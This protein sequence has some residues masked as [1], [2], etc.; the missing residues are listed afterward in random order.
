MGG[1]AI[2]KVPVIRLEK[3]R[4][5]D[6]KNKI[7]EIFSPR[8]QID[9]LI[10]VPGKIDFGDLDVLYLSESSQDIKNFIIEKIN[11]IE[12]VSNGD[13]LSIGYK[14]ESDEYFQ[15]DFIKCKNINTSKF[16]FSYG[17]LGS[18]IGRITKYYGLTFGSDGL[19]INI[20]SQTVN[21]YIEESQIEIVI[22]GNKVK[23]QIDQ[24]WNLGKIILSDNP[25]SICKYLDL[26][27]ELWNKGFADSNEIFN[28]IIKSSWYSHD[29]FNKLN[30]EHR[31]R[32]NLRPFYQKFVEYIFEI[33][34]LQP[35]FQKAFHEETKFNL[36]FEAIKWF[37]KINE[38]DQLIL[39]YNKN[40]E[41]HEKFNGN[42]LLNIG[43]E[44]K[45]LGNIIKNFKFYIQ[46]KYSLEFNLWLDL[47]EN[48]TINKQL[49][50]F[51]ELNQTNI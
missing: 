15:I 1:K 4:Y 3:S 34:G 38:L 26:D 35:D 32:F 45:N 40:V 29:I 21:K 33:Q 27:Y 48:S 43:I 22:K 20:L 10:E 47:N 13:V 36:Q 17:D 30:C 23:D 25:E 8:F 18:I 31:R 49:V 9:F 24:T 51:L 12:M 14:L 50:D 44:S 6:L 5:D 37:N 46:S 42:M 7:F 28:W 2:K 11:P 39:I 41:R 19:W 16:Y